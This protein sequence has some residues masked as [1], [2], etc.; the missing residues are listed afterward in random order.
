MKK[1][2][3]LLFFMVFMLS[4]C[5]NPFK[6]YAKDYTDVVWTSTE[7]SDLKMKIYAIDTCENAGRAYLVELDHE[8]IKYEFKGKIGSNLMIYKVNEYGSSIFEEKK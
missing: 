4:G 3:V 5:L 2:V 7:N 6:K 8:N 1:L